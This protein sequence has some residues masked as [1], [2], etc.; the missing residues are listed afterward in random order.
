MNKSWGSFVSGHRG[1]TAP[2]GPAFMRSVA[3]SAALLP[4]A[5][6]QKINSEFSVSGIVRGPGA[7]LV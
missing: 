5:L 2:K 4:C 6:T 7:E 3:S 1:A